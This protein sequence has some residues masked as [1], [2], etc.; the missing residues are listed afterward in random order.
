MYVIDKKEA[1]A[2]I[3]VKKSRFIASIFYLESEDE[4]KQ[5]LINIKKEFFD[6][7][8]NCYAYVIGN[9]K[10]MSDDGEPQGTGGRPIM[11]LIEG[12]EI[13]NIL[14]VVSRIFGGVLLG[15]G[16]LARAYQD[17]AKEAL[18]KI[19]LKK[20]IYGKEISTRFSYENLTI[21]QNYIKN[22]VNVKICDIEYGE[23]VNM[24]VNLPKDRSIDILDQLK[25]ITNGKIEII[26]EKEI[27]YIL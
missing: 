3:I 9:K 16:G 22:V 24:N 1:R 25:N 27:K 2:E 8:H 21:I 13:D 23:I 12:E 15:T 20:L 4:V 14:I 5:K 26:K 11:S 19:E 18:K 7:R 10:K 6:A 17:A